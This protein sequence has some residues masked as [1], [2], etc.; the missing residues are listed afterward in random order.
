V[1]ERER[2]CVCVWVCSKERERERR[3]GAGPYEDADVCAG[4]H[5]YMNESWHTYE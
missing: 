3:F 2:E 4:W 5:I 1:T